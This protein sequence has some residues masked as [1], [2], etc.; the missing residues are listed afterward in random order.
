MINIP[1]QQK[2]DELLEKVEQL[3]GQNLHAC[4]Q[5]GSC[6]AGCP[7]VADMDIIPEKIIRHVIF[8]L[9]RVLESQAI[10][11]CASCYLCVERCPRSID[12]A[13]I[14]EALRHIK[15]RQQNTDH[16]NVSEIAPEVLQEVPPI[17][18]VANFR[19]NTG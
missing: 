9:P 17:A 12:M 2:P 7:F 8:G 10:W 6:S 4:Y 15:M 19:K 18:L 14:M 5:C 16:I 1:A 3:S 11:M 13:K